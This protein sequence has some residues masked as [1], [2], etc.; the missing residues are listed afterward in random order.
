LRKPDGFRRPRGFT[1]IELLVVLALLVV[2]LG[3]LLPVLSKARSA[4]VDVR[5]RSQLR[6]LIAATL[7]YASDKEGML[8]ARFSPGY[9]YPHQMNRTPN[10]R[11]FLTPFLTSY[12]KLPNQ[13][14]FCPGQQET[15]GFSQAAL[16]GETGGSAA[17][18]IAAGDQWSTLQYH[19]WP[20]NS[21]FWAASMWPDQRRLST[22]TVNSPLW[23]CLTQVKPGGVSGHRIVKGLPTGMYV[24]FMNGSVSWVDFKETEVWWQNGNDKF[25]WPIY[26]Y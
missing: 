16:V 25:Y 22:S 11:Y 8:P 20:A 17:N 21:G 6:Q 9:G 10:G 7:A 12:L 3:L 19:P 2:L 4:A 18:L 13:V 5:C 23:S 26:K 14:V 1:F 24:A 15:G